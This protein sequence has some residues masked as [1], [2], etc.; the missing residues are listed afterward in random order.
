MENQESQPNPIHLKISNLIQNNK[1]V[2]DV[3]CG[4]GKLAQMLN[5]NYC[6]VFCIEFDEKRAKKARKYYKHLIVGDVESI[7]LSSVYK[8]YFDYIIFADV[9]EHLRDPENVL[10]RFKKYLKDDG[11]IVASI[12]NITNWRI[13]ISLLFGNFNYQD[14]GI[15]N[16]GHL[17]FFSKDSATKLF[18]EAGLKIVEFDITFGDYSRFPNFFHF[19]GMKWPNLFSFTFFF[20]AK[21]EEE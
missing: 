10:I 19:I 16:R 6:D 11:S 18:I 3:G 7:E 1:K 14:E 17:R 15:L 5:L 4:Y 8:N 20:V 12:P 9:L 13:R 2:L 21:K